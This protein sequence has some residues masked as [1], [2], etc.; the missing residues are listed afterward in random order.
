[1][2]LAREFGARD[3]TFDPYIPPPAK[4]PTLCEIIHPPL[5]RRALKLLEASLDSVGLD[6][7]ECAWTEVSDR[8]E[9]TS[10]RRAYSPFILLVGG[11]PVKWWRG[12]VTVARTRGFCFKMGG[13]RAGGEYALFPITHPEAVLQGGNAG[14]KKEM[15]EDLAR[16]AAVCEGRVSP[17][18]L[19]R[20][21]CVGCDGMKGKP[22]VE[23]DAQWV[24]W[25]EGCARDRD[26]REA[27]RDVRARTV[28]IYDSLG[29]KVGS[30]VLSKNQGRLEME[31]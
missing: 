8:G 28:G 12:D 13:T 6:P 29:R 21:A 4:H 26:D 20:D 10:G 3:Y 5:S 9:G 31:G 24:S 11:G 14:V 1:M 16:W 30:T 25:C 18:V 15:L 2:N 22:I 7:D 17:L 19:R 23:V 27:R